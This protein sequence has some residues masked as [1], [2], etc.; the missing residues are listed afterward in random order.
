MLQQGADAQADNNG[1]HDFRSVVLACAQLPEFIARFNHE[2]NCRLSSPLADLVD[3]TW[4][5]DLHEGRGPV[6]ERAVQIAAFVAFVHRTVWQPY[7]EWSS[8]SCSIA[9]M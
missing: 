3:D 8:R 6:Q 9:A 1:T 2:R 5:L 7:L 4:V